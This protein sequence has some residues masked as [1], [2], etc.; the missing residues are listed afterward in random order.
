[1]H[2]Q[3]SFDLIGLETLSN[4]SGAVQPDQKTLFSCSER[5]QFNLKTIKG[6]LHLYISRSTS[7]HE[8]STVPNKALYVHNIESQQRSCDPL[9]ENPQAI[10]LS[11]KTRKMMLEQESF[12][13]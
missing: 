5:Q 3:I 8:V 11:L 4:G 6:Q 10:G 7:P 2:L 13:D 12:I 1:M 9:H